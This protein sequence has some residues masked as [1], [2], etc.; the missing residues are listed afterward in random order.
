MTVLS[1]FC[2]FKKSRQSTI[3][4]LY[5]KTLKNGHVGTLKRLRIAKVIRVYTFFDKERKP[6]QEGDLCF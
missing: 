2:S 4:N 3:P 5:P 6:D 1:C